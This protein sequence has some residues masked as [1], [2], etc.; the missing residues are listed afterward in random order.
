METQFV[1]ISDLPVGAPIR[2]QDLFVS[3]QDG[4]TVKVLGA[5]FQPFISAYL[6]S[7]GL[8]DPNA[9]GQSAVRVAA[10]TLTG[11]DIQAQRVTLPFTPV[12]PE[13]ALVQLETGIAQYPNVDFFIEGNQLKWSGLAMELLVE[14]GQRLHVTYQ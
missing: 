4:V 5:D 6:A 9:P 7:I 13:K 14:A 11:S 10:Y 1:K 3:V 2:D 12:N 8:G